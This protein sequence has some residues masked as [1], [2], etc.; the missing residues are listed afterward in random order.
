MKIY[1]LFYITMKV[2]F[3][4]YDHFQIIKKMSA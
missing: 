2:I 4:E 3:E 1:R